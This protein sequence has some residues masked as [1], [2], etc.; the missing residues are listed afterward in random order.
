LNKFLKSGLIYPKAIGLKLEKVF[1][2]FEF[3]R[4][5]R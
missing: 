4:E 2:F 3:R 1:E 5:V